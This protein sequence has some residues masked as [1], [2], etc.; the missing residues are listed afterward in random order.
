VLSVLVAS[1]GTLWVA[2]DNGLSSMDPDH[3]GVFRNYF[4]DP[5]DLTTLSNPPFLSLFEDS[6]DRLWIGAAHG[7]NRLESADQGTFTRFLT[8]PDLTL[9]R[10]GPFGLPEWSA[11]LR[12]LER[13]EEPGIIWFGSDQGLIRFDATEDTWE[14]FIPRRD[15]DNQCALFAEATQDP[16]NPGVLWIADNTYGLTR[17]DTRTESFATFRNDPEDPSSVQAGSSLRM[18]TDRSGIVWVGNFTGGLGRFDPTSIGFAHHRSIPGNP[19]SL[20]NSAIYGLYQSRDGVIWAATAGP[21]GWVVSALDRANNR[22]THYRHDPGEASSLGRGSPSAIFEDRAGTIW[23]GSGQGLNRLNRDTGR[24]T[25]FRANPDDPTAL[26]SDEVTAITDDQAGN[27]W[28]GGH[29]VVQRM[30]AGEP[31]RFQRYLHDPDDETTILGSDVQSITEDLAGFIWVTSF[32]GTSRL[33]PKTGRATRY[34]HNP[35]D[36]ESLSA[37]Q[38]QYA[39][40]RK[41][42]PGVIWMA[43]F[44]GGLDRLDVATGKVRHFTE[45]QGLSNNSVYGFVED[46]EG[47]LWLSTN[48]GLSRFDP[49]TETFR[50]YGTEIGL[51]SLEFN[52]GAFHRGP[53]GEFFFGGVNGLN[54]FYP[55]ELGD[56]TQA[57]E[58]TLVDLKLFNES[59]VGSD[60]VALH[61]SISDAEEVV[62]DH[63]QNDIEFD[64]VALHFKDPAK[65]EYAY[66]LEGWNDDWVYVDN[67]RSASFTNLDPGEYT[68]RVKAANAD[69][70]WNEEGASIRLVITP[71][72]WSTW[73]FRILALLAFAGV[74]AGGYRIR[75]QQLAARA[76]EL[77]G[78]VDERTAAL[79]ESNDQLEQSA[80]IVE[81]INQE[82]SFRRLL[83]KILEEARVMPGVEK[84]TALIRMPEDDLF[85]VRASSGW[86]VSA[87]ADIRLTDADAHSRYVDRTEELSDNIFV[88]RNAKDRAGAETMAEFGQVASFMVLRVVVEEEVVAYLVFDNL[89][90][91]DAFAQRDVDLLRRLQEHITSAFIKTRILED[92][93]SQRSGLQEALDDLRST[94]DRLVQSEKMASLGQLTAGIAHEIRNPLNFVNNFSEMSAE[95]AEDMEK[96][97]ANR[98]DDLPDDLL[99]SLQDMIDTLKVNASKIH[100]HGERAESIVDNMLEHSKG[101][102]GERHPTD[103]N[104]L[105]DEYVTLAHHGLRIRYEDLDVHINREYDENVGKVDIVPQEMGRV[106]MNLLG[107]AFDAL[108]EG[109]VGSEEGGVPTVTISTSKSGANI[110]IRVV[111][112]GP[113]IPPK[114]K[115]R[116]F[117][118]FFT[119]KPTGTGTGLG[120]SMSYDIITKSHGGSLEVESVEGEGAT[121]IVRLPA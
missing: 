26:F 70:I 106:F 61:G 46:D 78:L 67:K 42:E 92:R 13:P 19:N 71:P 94:Q 31:G 16:V 57:P 63:S 25:H 50:N 37:N 72:F 86:D 32:R 91:E 4:H 108:E 99:A 47:N 40:E 112:N 49:D 84:A 18:Y 34:V 74:I 36:P 22:V 5:T 104:A 53:Y 29:D 38:V 11:V 43:L 69:G 113:G 87:M 12:A 110:E 80:T 14:R 68:F 58:I 118:P 82:T 98:K 30:R 107:N 109:G 95:L 59:I 83:T 120:L 15:D 96:E 65:N 9:C 7:L 1:D 111:D 90:D 2:T 93:E 76:T 81:A 97:L 20:A 56:N 21:G 60:D 115:E 33:D 24:F 44:G 62:L 23:V 51:Q 3:P 48:R 10:P 100:E 102:E 8:E 52:S 28:I 35:D 101:G 41:S 75:T 114:V 119:T 64:F 73:W 6:S 77:E 116:I 85:H 79:K 54:S 39:Y 66:K 89:Q 27:M 55:N 88:A 45:R 103:L 105:L 121:F 117:E 17:F